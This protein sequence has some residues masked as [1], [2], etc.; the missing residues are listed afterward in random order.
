MASQQRGRTADGAALGRAIHLRY[1]RPV[2]FADDY[3]LDLVSPSARFLCRS[4]LLYRLL[5]RRGV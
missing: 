1:E 4:S 3:A 2:V 5:P